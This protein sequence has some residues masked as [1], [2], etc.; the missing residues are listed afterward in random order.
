MKK[1]LKSALILCCLTACDSSQDL[2]EERLPQ[3]EIYSI[4]VYLDE[5][6]QNT[7]DVRALEADILTVQIGGKETSVLP[8]S[9]IIQAAMPDLDTESKLDAYLEKHLCDYESGSDGFRPSSRGDRCP[10]VSCLYTKL[11]Y[12]SLDSANLI[13]DDGAPDNLSV[14]CYSVTSLKKVLLL[15][16]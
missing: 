2:R 7:I 13:Y 5:S 10:P 15:T 6:L 14:G 12:F 3:D 1:L 4:G 8:V 11:S 16:N 9:R